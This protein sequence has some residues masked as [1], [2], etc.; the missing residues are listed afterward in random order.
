MPEILTILEKSLKNVSMIYPL[1]VFTFSYAQN[2]RDIYLLGLIISFITYG[3]YSAIIDYQ[4]RQAIKTKS[5]TVYSIG[6]KVIRH[7]PTVICG[8]S[9]FVLYLWSLF[10]AYNF[11]DRLEGLI[12]FLYGISGLVYLASTILMEKG[13]LRLLKDIYKRKLRISR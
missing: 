1:L 9:A 12:I 7:L 11:V 13:T 4:V 10:I 2:N 3:F 8:L 5:F 6:K